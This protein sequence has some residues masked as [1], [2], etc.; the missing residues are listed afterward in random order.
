L[1]A[2]GLR[3]MGRARQTLRRVARVSRGRPSWPGIA[4]EDD[5]AV[6]VGCGAVEHGHARAPGMVAATARKEPAG[7]TSDQSLWNMTISL[8]DPFTANRKE[9]AR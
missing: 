5:D 9:S 7:L 8:T 4:I 1:V 2:E 6:S 3:R